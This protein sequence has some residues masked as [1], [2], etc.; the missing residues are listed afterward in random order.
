MEMKLPQVCQAKTISGREFPC[1]YK[2][3]NTVQLGSGETEQVLIHA[4]VMSTGTVACLP[5]TRMQFFDFLGCT[6][7]GMNMYESE[8]VFRWDRVGCMAAVCEA[9]R[10]GLAGWGLERNLGCSPLCKQLHVKTSQTSRWWKH[11]QRGWNT[12]SCL[13]FVTI[14]LFSW[15]FHQMWQINKKI[16]GAEVRHCVFGFRRMELAS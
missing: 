9:G 15:F 5:T 3:Q 16:N 4:S 13:C 8:V 14:K 6:N 2:W 12:V 7:G 1:F 10:K 11:Y